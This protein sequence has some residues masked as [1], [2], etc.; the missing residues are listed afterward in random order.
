MLP[1]ETEATAM[2]KDVEEVS[3]NPFVFSGAGGSVEWRNY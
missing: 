1:Q 3:Y 2:P